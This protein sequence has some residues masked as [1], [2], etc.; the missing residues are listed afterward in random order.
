MILLNLISFGRDID[1]AILQSEQFHRSCWCCCPLV[2]SKVSFEPVEDEEEEMSFSSINKMPTGKKKKPQ[3]KKL[4]RKTVVFNADQI[5]DLQSTFN[6]FDADKDGSV[7]TGDIKRVLD[8]NNI[9]IT[10]EDLRAIMDEVDTDKSGM[11][12]VSWVCV[13]R[14][15]LCLHLRVLR[16]AV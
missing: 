2:M 11:I 15:V 12:E 9:K 7:S 8:S 10:D 3:E 4:E 5:K 13:M 6:V 1:I 16:V 14:S